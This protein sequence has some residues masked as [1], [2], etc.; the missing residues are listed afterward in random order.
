MRLIFEKWGD[1]KRNKFILCDGDTKIETSL[2]T[3]IETA[4]RAYSPT[5]DFG[6][7]LFRRHIHHN[8]D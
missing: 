8:K 7:T 4:L 3:R 5:N 6:V 2:V 1:V